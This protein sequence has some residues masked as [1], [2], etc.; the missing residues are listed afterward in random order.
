[1]SEWDEYRKEAQNNLIKHCQLNNATEILSHVLSL[2]TFTFELYKL[3]DDTIDHVLDSVKRVR[4]D[5][6][7]LKKK[8]Q[9]DETL[10]KF[11]K[12]M[13]SSCSQ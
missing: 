11:I 3:D 9:I 10:D 6:T 4:K 13:G 5:P 12:H 1:M 7:Y 2:L 8:S